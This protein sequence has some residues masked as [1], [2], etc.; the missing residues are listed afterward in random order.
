MAVAINP[1]TAALA[2]KPAGPVL[3]DLDDGTVLDVRT[4]LVWKKECEP[5]KFTWDDAVAAFEGGRAPGFAGHSDW[6]MPTIEELKTLIEKDQKP[7]INTAVFGQVAASYYWS[8]SSYAGSP[9]G[10]WFVFFGNGVGYYYFKSSSV[11]VRLV[12]GG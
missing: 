9:S 8:S 3:V 11:Y 6:R 5:K 4:R 10:A 7:A 1:I 12:R 2:A